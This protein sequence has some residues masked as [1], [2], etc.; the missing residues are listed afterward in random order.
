MQ[1]CSD[2]LREKLATL[3]NHAKMHRQIAQKNLHLKIS[4]TQTLHE[5][6]RLA[7]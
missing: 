7:G 3:Q 4:L 5:A 2:K 1:K 6:F